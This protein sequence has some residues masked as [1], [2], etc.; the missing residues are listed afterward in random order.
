MFP[1]EQKHSVMT[2]SLAKTKQWHRPQF[3]CATQKLHAIA[4]ACNVIVQPCQVMRLCQAHLKGFMVMCSHSGNAN[5]VY[6]VSLVWRG[7]VMH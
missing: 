1:D 6:L 2:L 5:Y 7:R 4:M 3:T